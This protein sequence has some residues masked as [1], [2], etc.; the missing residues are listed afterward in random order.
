SKWIEQP[1]EMG[2]KCLIDRC[3]P[4]PD[5][6]CDVPSRCLDNK[7]ALH[8]LGEAKGFAMVKCEGD[9]YCEGGHC[10]GAVCALGSTCSAMDNQ[11]VKCVAGKSFENSQCAVNE[12]CKA[13]RD[14][15]SCVPKPCT[16]GEI[17][18]GDPRDPKVDV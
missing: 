15:A 9:T 17:K 6:S 1:C 10:R 3:A 5:A 18:C 12:V 2:D 13:E 16:P 14:E 8:C 7:K 4:D 11:V